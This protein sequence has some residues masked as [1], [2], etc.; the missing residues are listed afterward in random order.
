MNLDPFESYEDEDVWRALESA[1]LSNFVSGLTEKLEYPI[2]EGGE[3]LRWG[4]CVWV[5]VACV[6]V[7]TCV[8]VCVCV[9][10][11]ALQTQLV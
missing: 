4:V 11:C 8:C 5:C 9:C 1:H 2:A 6:W 3:N 7:C 10:G